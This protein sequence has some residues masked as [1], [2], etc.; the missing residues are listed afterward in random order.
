M[1]VNYVFGDLKTGEIIEEIPLF[2][3]SMADGLN[4]DGELRGSLALDISGKQNLD[5]VAATIP[6]R[7]YVVAELNTIPVWGGIVWSRTYQATSKT[8]QLYCRGFEVYPFRRFIRQSLSFTN[9]EQT[10]IFT[11]LWNTMQ[12]VPDGHLRVEVPSSIATGVNKTMSFT[13]S[14]FKTYGQA[15]SQLADA[16]DGFDWKIRTVRDGGVYRRILAIGYPT[17]GAAASESSTVLEYPGAITNY[18]ETDSIGSSG[19]DIYLFGAG[20]GN[21]MLTSIQTHPDLLSSGWVIFDID[22][23]YK[24]VTKQSILNSIGAQEKKKR[25][26]PA[27]VLKAEVKADQDPVFGSYG[28][29]DSMKVVLN[30]PKHNKETTARRVV[31]WEFWPPDADHVGHAILT[32]ENLEEE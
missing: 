28:L 30:D 18:W 1:S 31:R 19:T 11:S 14:E 10:S 6:G 16:F 12:S 15:M 23:P 13:P 3:V 7:C 8:L 4:S 20:E 21:S 32:F 5:L 25:R 9:Q 29:G 27:I 26:A 22:A 17:L 2:G 24:D